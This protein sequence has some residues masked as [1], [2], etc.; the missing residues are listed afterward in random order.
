MPCAAPIKPP[1]LV[2]LYCGDQEE[3]AEPNPPGPDMPPAL[4]PPTPPTLRPAP[5]NPSKPL[6]PPPPPACAMPP[7]CPSIGAAAIFA[8]EVVMNCTKPGMPPERPMSPARGAPIVC[9]NVDDA[10][11]PKSDT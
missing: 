9:C 10:D 11:D 8:N 7:S 2:V 5:I 1:P 6:P 3:P 4:D